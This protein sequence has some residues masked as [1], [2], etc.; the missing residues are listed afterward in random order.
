MQ[1]VHIAAGAL[2]LGGLFA[3]LLGIRGL[4]GEARG[5]AVRRFSTTAG[6]ALVA[7][8]A[9]GTVRAVIE[10]GAWDRLTSTTFGKLVLVKI[11]LLLL[12]AGLGAVNR[13][14]NV[15]KASRVVRGL[16]R[17]GSIEVMVALGALVVAA[18]LVNEEPP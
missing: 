10:I 16:Q 17:V 8:A 9:S 13:F 11:A 4:T 3:L 12:L 14:G 7:V 18:A 5:R 6:I 1:W 15:P 2:W